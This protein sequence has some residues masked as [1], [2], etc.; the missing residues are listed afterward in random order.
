[1]RFRPRTFHCDLHSLTL[2]LDLC[3][4]S[5]WAH[6]YTGPR[7]AGRSIWGEFPTSPR[8]MFQSA[9]GIAAGR[10]RSTSHRSRSTS[11]FQSAPGIAA[12]RCHSRFV[13]V[14]GHHQFQSAPGIA[15]GRCSETAGRATGIDG[16]QSAPGIAAGRCQ[17]SY[18]TVTEPAKV[19]IR[20]RHCCR[21]MRA[22]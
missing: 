21:A 4:A 7:T 3:M 1:M 12:G 2:D 8:E 19:S 11:Q 14:H 20:A 15:A 13:M 10:C 17:S 6:S 18:R 22:E 5:Y 16:F 9:P